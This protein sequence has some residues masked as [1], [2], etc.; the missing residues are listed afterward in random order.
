MREIIGDGLHRLL[1]L[2]RV[3]LQHLFD[4]RVDARIDGGKTRDALSLFDHLD[5]GA[6]HIGRRALQGLEQH[7]TEAVDVRPGGDVAAV[8]A[9]L[10]GRDIVE[11]AGEA[12]VDERGPDLRRARDAE[13]DDLRLVD[14][15]VLDNDVARTTSR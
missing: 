1:P 3:R 4:D 2:V 12:D 10:L 8:K 13:V 11:F 14:I 7:K 5:L 6:A 9:E 15:A